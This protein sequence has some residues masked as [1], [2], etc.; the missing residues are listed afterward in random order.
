MAV[1]LDVHSGFLAGDRIWF[2]YAR[3]RQLFHN[4][5]E[6]WAL[7][8]LLSAAHENHVYTVEPQALN[9]T[10]HG[11]LWDYLYDDYLKVCEGRTW[12]PL[13]LEMSSYLWYRK[14]PR[15][16]LNR[17]GLFHPVK[18]H[19]TNAGCLQHRRF[20]LG[21][22]LSR[23]VTGSTLALTRLLANCKFNT[24]GRAAR[25]LQGTAQGQLLRREAT[26]LT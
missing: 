12:L 2:P 5:P 13:T 6:V 14:N 18:P 10:T 7:N 3:T 11:D 19:R 4:V 8:E 21:S 22:W 24:Q 9:Y 1:S 25:E 17:F 15:Q 20:E 16:L 23:A 26:L